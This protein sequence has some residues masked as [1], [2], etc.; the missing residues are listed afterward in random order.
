MKKLLV[1][2]ALVIGAT[3]IGCGGKDTAEVKPQVTTTA[4][5]ATIP[6]PTAKCGTCKKTIKTVLT[7][8]AGISDV[9]F[10]GEAPSMAVTVSFD[11]SKT[12]EKAICQTIGKAGYNAKDVVRDSAAYENLHECC[13]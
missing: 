5:S 13:K 11:P 3:L 8:D 10:S 9:S 4:V 2:S 7:A 1:L 12:N 6:L